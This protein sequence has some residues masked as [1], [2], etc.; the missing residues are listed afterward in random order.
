MWHFIINM[1]CCIESSH[2]SNRDTLENRCERTLHRVEKE[3]GL[4]SFSV[5]KFTTGIARFAQDQQMTKT[6]LI[7][8]LGNLGF[9]TAFLD[10]DRSPKRRFFERL[11]N[12]DNKT[13]SAVKLEALGILLCSDTLNNK[14]HALFMNYDRDCSNNIDS[15]ELTSM[16]EDICY[17]SID[18]ILDLAIESGKESEKADLGQYKNLLIDQKKKLVNYYMHIL[19]YHVDNM[20]R[21]VFTRAL[22]EYGVRR[23]FSSEGCRRMAYEYANP[24]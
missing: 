24:S 5:I 23:L 20:T 21:E 12:R 8:G 6:Q 9:D 22:Q 3:L 16:I 13:F 18:C 2:E 10:A 7:K 15:I 19:V 4:E 11:M 1:G 17:I 14:A